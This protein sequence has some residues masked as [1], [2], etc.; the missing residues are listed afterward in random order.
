MAHL[1]TKQLK[2]GAE[3][4]SIMFR[5][6]GRQREVFLSQQ[7]RKQEAEEIADIVGR[8]VDCLTTGNP[9]TRTLTAWLEGMPPDLRARFERAGLVEKAENNPAEI[10]IDQLFDRWF[11]YPVERKPNTI[12][13]YETTQKRVYDFF[14]PDE[15]ITAVTVERALSFRLYQLNRKSRATVGGFVKGLRALWNFGIKLGVAEDNPWKQV[16]ED[17]Q[18]NPARKAFIPLEWYQR[19]LAACP[20]QEWRTLLAFCRIGGIRC[21]SETRGLLWS[22]INWDSRCFMVRSPKTERFEGHDTRVT[23]LFPELEAEASRLWAMAEEGDDYVFP[24]LRDRENH[25]T[26][27]TK[28]IFRAGLCPWPRA[29]NNLR[30]SRETELL[31]TFPAHVV[32]GWLGHSVEVARKHYVMVRPEDLETGAN[33][34]TPVGRSPKTANHPTNHPTNRVKLS[35]TE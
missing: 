35:E 11:R 29:F 33:Y 22:D 27:F 30:A 21:D 34:V 31:Q 4:F 28:I 20:N 13:N 7:Y 14:R 32:S 16:P 12:R 8:V 3:S 19:L 23:P 6:G 10:T 17:A 25:R 26:T 15:P 9:P 1:K 2:N 24:N 18:E 5:L